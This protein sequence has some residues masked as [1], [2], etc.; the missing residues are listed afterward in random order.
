MT[1][2]A[3]TTALKRFWTKV[4]ALVPTIDSALSS[5]STNPVQNKVINTALA[6][7]QAKLTAG[8]NITLSGSTISA[9][10]PTVNNG[11]LTIKQNGSQLGTFTA[12]QSGSTT[13]DIKTDSSTILLND[14]GLSENYFGV[15]LNAG[16]TF[17]DPSA[18][19]GYSGTPS[20]GFTE[21]SSSSYNSQISTFMRVGF[22][23]GTSALSML[24]YGGGGLGDPYIQFDIDDATTS[25]SGLMSAS[26][27]KK[28]NGLPTET[29]LEVPYE[30]GITF[31]V[32]KTKGYKAI[33]FNA[34]SDDGGDE[35]NII[36]GTDMIG[37]TI[38]IFNMCSGKIGLNLRN[39]DTN[40]MNIYA[41]SSMASSGSDSGG[42]GGGTTVGRTVFLLKAKGAIQVTFIPSSDGV[43]GH[44]EAIAF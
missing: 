17:C 3:S 21:F 9:S 30:A 5:T 18:S 23:S 27:K 11:T 7:K 2:Y 32:R 36:V 10:Q 40:T 6:G 22:K 1:K 24:A 39:D 37:Q 34:A 35:A 29:Y 41:R 28:L 19:V 12:N 33:I 4:K 14:V 31:T 44:V 15:S 25:A 20:I 26:D 38:T 8:T 43:S 42:T 13:V 16:G